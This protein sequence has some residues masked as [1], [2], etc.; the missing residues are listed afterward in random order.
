MSKIL[1]PGVHTANDRLS[2]FYH[3]CLDRDARWSKILNSTDIREQMND[4]SDRGWQAL[5]QSDYSTADTQYSQ[6]LN[7]ARQLQDML[8][9]A[10]FLSYLA[11][12]KRGSGNKDEA[13]VLLEQSLEIAEAESDLRVVAHVS[14]LLS[15]L[16]CDDNDENAAIVQLWRALDAALE[17]R[18]GG[19][20]EVSFGKLGEIYRN[21]GWLEQAAEC[22]SQA[23]EIMPDGP[24]RVAWLGNLGQTLAE[25]NDFASAMEIYKQALA[26]AE[27]RG[28]LKA[29]SRCF[30]SK[31]LVYFEERRF[32]EAAVC[33]E[34]ALQ[35]ARDTSDK[36][37]EAAW[38]GN[39]GNVLLKQGKVEDA[40]TF[41]RAGLELARELGDKRT[42]AAHFD[43][44]GDCY[45]A[46][47]D[48]EQALSYYEL[49]AAAAAAAKD[50]PGERV[51]FAN[52][53]KALYRLGKDS[54]A[55]KAY[56]HAVELFEE[57]RGRICSD[58]LKTSFAASGQEIYKDVIQLCVDTGR[59]VEALEYVG[60]AKSR[61][62]LDL[63]ANSPIDISELAAVDDDTIARLISKEMEL[64][65]RI[66]GLE[67]MFGQGGDMETGHRGVQVSADDVPKLY[68]EWRDIV[69]QLKRRHPA[70]AGM[71]SVDTLKFG[72]LKRLWDQNR[73]QSNAAII[74]FFWTE[75]FLLAA[76]IRE[77][78]AQPETHLLN[79]DEIAELEA[80]LWD[81]LEMSAT[82][83]WEVPVSLCRRLYDRLMAPLIGDL[84]DSIE[85]LVL[86]PHGGLHRLPFAALHDGER[87][88]IEKYAISVIPSASL[89]GLL[90]SD[91]TAQ[92]G[93]ST[94]YLVSAI[95]DYSATRDEGIVFSARLRSSAGL[96]DLSY[97]LEEG[98]TVF[99]LANEIAIDARLLTN[100]EVKDGLLHHFREYSVIHFAGHAV[101]NPEEPLAS[102]LVLSDGSVLTAARILE[103]STFRTSCGK[104]LVLSACQTGVNVITTGGEIIGLARALIYAGMRNII[105]SLWEV[106][107]LSTAGLMQDF[108]RIWQGG[109]STIADAL[110]EAQCRALKEGQPVHAWAPFVHTGID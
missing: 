41:C 85:R 42:E 97:T 18:D 102:G 11:V 28:D 82:E 54:E 90:G 75:E 39:V 100:E 31:G 95:S 45:A 43:S 14:Y 105:S 70:Y 9:A 67:R 83:G 108:H 19:T 5:E 38:L 8:A 72:D 55:Y 48:F 79:R 107:D 49:A 22:F 50:R 63:L 101:F 78:I 4:A 65:S 94:R 92:Q 40:R 53:G 86:V 60:R 96:E 13:R 110:R 99:G 62:M 109:R 74:E 59:R 51:Y 73:L 66:A 89:I 27:K 77:G 98:Q 24:N 88:L 56:E 3:L 46:E 64:R 87:Y 6:A 68:K 37:A 71:V 47:E 26:E 52:Q 16:D 80:E 93:E 30:A 106:A 20:A 91:E 61:A 57:Q 7:A 36:K 84:P 81:F 2:G 34:Q 69:D 76:C 58:A 104:L 33:F 12:A 1:L 23:S 44:L 29:S 10:V 21:R 35:L 103:D 32:D 15:E 25:M 17:V